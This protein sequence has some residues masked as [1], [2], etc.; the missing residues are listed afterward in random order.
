[1][2]NLKN[3]LS[4]PGQIGNIFV[5]NYLH[6]FRQSGQ[7]R[8][9]YYLDIGNFFYQKKFDGPKTKFGKIVFWASIFFLTLELKSVKSISSS[10]AKTLKRPIN[11]F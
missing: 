8:V 11:Y 1:M 7:I 2:A 4:V 5:K 9:S 3:S 10:F 6:I